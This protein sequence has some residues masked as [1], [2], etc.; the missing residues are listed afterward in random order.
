MVVARRIGSLVAVAL[1]LEVAAELGNER[2]WLMRGP[3]SYGRERAKLGL[4][5]KRGDHQPGG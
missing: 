4:H 3:H 5:Q 1:S 2:R